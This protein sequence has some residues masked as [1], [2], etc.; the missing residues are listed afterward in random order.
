MI[1]Y[2]AKCELAR[3]R[4]FYYCKLKAK[5]FYNEQRPYIVRLCDELQS[6]IEG[7]DDVLVMNMPPRHGKSR[8]GQMLVEFL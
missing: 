6:F 5:D 7:D 3:R 4:F 1:A 2:G 8:T